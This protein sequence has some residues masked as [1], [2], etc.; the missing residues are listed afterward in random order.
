MEPSH[1]YFRQIVEMAHQKNN[2]INPDI[3]YSN[4][5]IVFP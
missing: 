3:A 2:K 1:F 5:N 4:P